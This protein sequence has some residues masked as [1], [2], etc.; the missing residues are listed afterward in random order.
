MFKN[1]CELALKITFHVYETT[2]SLLSQQH[3]SRNLFCDWTEA[4][5][6]ALPH[7]WSDSPKQSWVLT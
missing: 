4:L 6:M 5:H 2:N 1:L 7:F 3:S